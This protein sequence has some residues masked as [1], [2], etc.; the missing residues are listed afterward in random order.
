M[1]KNNRNKIISGVFVYLMFSAC[2]IPKI[3][4]RKA[5][6]DVPSTYQH[7]TDS[8]NSAKLSWKNFFTDPYLSALIDTALKNNQELNITM[9]EILISQNEV[10]TRKGEYLPSVGIGAGAGLEKRAR[11]TPFGANEA[12]TEIKP[13]TEMPEPVPDFQLG[14]Y[15]S[16]ELDVW[17]KLRN[18]KRAAV[19]N[20]L[21]SVEGKNFM[22]TS[23]IA[24]IANSY[25]ELLALDNEMDIVQKNITI[26]NN[27]FE[28]VKQQKQAAKVTELA[29]KRFEAQL[30][31]T[32]AMQYTIKQDIVETENRLNFLVGRYP[33]K[34][35]RTFQ[36]FNELS[37]NG[38]QAGV[39]MQLLENRPDIKQAE[40]ELEAAKLDVK[41]AKARF[42][43]SLGV[44]AGVGLQAYKISLL[45]ST[46][47]SIMF[48]LVGDLMTPL[49]N[50][51]AIKAMYKSANNK[52]IQAVYNYEQT[53]LNAYVEVLNQLANIENMRN[54]YE[55]KKQEVA[56]LDQSIKISNDLFR[57]AR[58]DY[59][60]VLLTQREALDVKFELIETKMKQ[61]AARV[62]VYRALGGG[63][64]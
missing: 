25:Y 60:E 14:A 62:N 52:Q 36:G 26:Q 39:P 10:R 50:R 20:Y 12:T 2:G 46:P 56:A 28:V 57:S 5:N 59:F 35:D 42:Y 16:W 19:A 33:Q 24:E 18:G 6:K 1:L 7:S 31:K 30:L 45:S 34:I 32:R 15:A 8:T 47:E 64:E 40:L 13:G 53:I 23:L 9:Q 61:M 29:V 17:Q 3:T 54:S 48:S 55:L 21:A 49:I 38:I 43:P 58:A 44:S 22:V 37:T 51:N 4:Q 41:V 27:A 11:Y 63:W